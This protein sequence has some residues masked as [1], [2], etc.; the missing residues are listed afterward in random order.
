MAKVKTPERKATAASAGEAQLS[1]KGGI[2]PRHWEISLS[3]HKTARP[4]DP[5]PLI[6]AWITSHLPV[7]QI[8]EVTQ[9]ANVVFGDNTV[10]TSWLRNPN[11][12]TDNQSPVSLLGT[13]DGFERVKN[14]L[15]RIQYGVLA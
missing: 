11:L 5:T 1:S 8:E 4:N 14:L 6:D 10:A 15:L 2:R 12:A 9:L 13:S 3:L 7:D